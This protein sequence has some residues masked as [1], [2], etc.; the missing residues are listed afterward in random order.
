MQYVFFVLHGPTLDQRWTNV[1]KLNMCMWLLCSANIGLMNIFLVSC[2]QATIYIWSQ[3]V[4]NNGLIFINMELLITYDTITSLHLNTPTHMHTLT[5][6]YIHTTTATR[7]QQHST[8]H[9]HTH[10]Y[11][12]TH[13]HTH[14]QTHSHTHVYIHTYTDRQHINTHMYA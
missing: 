8:Q 7:T 3:L 12:L 10:T 14:V 4:F 2:L 13:T 9:T 5:H 11:S 1:R 6:I